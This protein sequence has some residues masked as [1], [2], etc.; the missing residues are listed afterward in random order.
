MK[1]ENLLEKK[2]LVPDLEI[3]HSSQFS[4]QVKTQIRFDFYKNN[5]EYKSN[6]SKL[7]KKCLYF[8]ATNWI[9]PPFKDLEQ[10]NSGISVLSRILRSKQRWQGKL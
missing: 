9:H 3:K 6:D 4:V 5:D 1:K 7:F 8:E 10:P 2:N